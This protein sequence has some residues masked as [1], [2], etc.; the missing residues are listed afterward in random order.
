MSASNNSD[1]GSADSNHGS[2]VND[3]SAGMS[4]GGEAILAVIKKV[5]LKHPTSELHKIPSMKGVCLLLRGA[6]VSSD[7][8]EEDP[9][10][11][12]RIRRG[13]EGILVE[14]RRKGN[15]YCLTGS[16]TCEFCQPLPPDYLRGVV[17]IA[18]ADAQAV[19]GT[20]KGHSLD[21]KSLMLH[22]TAA[23][24]AKGNRIL[25]TEVFQKILSDPPSGF[26]AYGSRNARKFCL[27]RDGM[28]NGCQ[29][30]VVRNA[31]VQSSAPCSQK[32]GADA[33][34]G[35]GKRVKQEAAP[36]GRKQDSAPPGRNQDAAPP[37]RNQD[38][39]SSSSTSYISADQAS[40]SASGDN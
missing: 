19:N 28:C 20:K 13:V 39:S 10:L 40:L 38:A 27:F 23:N 37:G 36:S 12:A 31:Q 2:A 9:A 33:V 32:R 14:T 4:E 1:H 26:S 35:V 22:L 15:K 8:L 5:V 11:A 21:F 25:A 30:P 7:G 6:A 24:K 18:A 3:D 16:P 34:D 17:G 29:P